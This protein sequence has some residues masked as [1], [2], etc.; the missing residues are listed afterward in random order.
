MPRKSS[1]ETVVFVTNVGVNVDGKYDVNFLENAK[2]AMERV[3]EKKIFVR[4]KDEV[5][6]ILM[7]VEDGNNSLELN[8]IDNYINVQLPSFD[9]I[10]KIRE[11]KPQDIEFKNWISGLQ[12]ALK[13]IS[14]QVEGSNRITIILITN[15]YPTNPFGNS[16]KDSLIQDITKKEVN[17]LWLGSKDLKNLED[18][19]L[20]V[21]ERMLFDL[22]QK[23]EGEY[24]PFSFVLP[25]LEF[26]GAH[27]T[28]P[29]PWK[30]NLE[31][32]TLKIPV[33]IY[34]SITEVQPLN[35]WQDISS[36]FD[37]NSA[38]ELH[39]VSKKRVLADRYR[40]EYKLED[41]VQGY[42]YGRKF[43][44]LTEE[45]SAV[46]KLLSEEK[47]FKLYG[48]SPEKFVKLDYRHGKKTHV[49][50]PLEGAEEEFFCLVK[51]M[52]DLQRVALV[53]KIYN[54]N[55]SPSMHVLYP[56]IGNGDKPWCFFMY[57]LIYSEERLIITPRSYDNVLKNIRQEQ[58]DCVDKLINLMMLGQSTIPEDENKTY[59]TCS[60]ESP[61]LQHLWNTLSS[62]AF[63][64]EASIPEPKL[65][66]LKPIQPPEWKN[67]NEL[68]NCIT[69]IISAYEI[70]DE[71]KKT[72]EP[73]DI[74]DVSQLTQQ[75]TIKK[76]TEPGDFLPRPM[77]VDL[78][79][80]FTD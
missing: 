52:A 42:M 39:S 54:K 36:S 70:K 47:S 75:P 26:Y 32:G 71:P 74:I 68:A 9:M 60:V 55:S 37:P 27:K 77:D 61:D 62:R 21:N 69:D 45:D 4:P 50:L 65:S 8:L 2:I 17:F 48:F 63:D 29:T 5:G 33:A 35:K 59:E 16:A 14:D 46:L 20:N 24:M 64:P 72:F 30:C 15:C 31:I 11:I 3:I 57:E 53:R 34:I 76:N 13:M 7:G 78:D 18:E 73:V 12:A 67:S 6:V 28:S 58:F 41:T 10:E 79:A 44:P 1:K 23:V 19:E 43:I 40:E 80:L 25:K 49:I 38:E 51:A 22:T 66:V 56:Q